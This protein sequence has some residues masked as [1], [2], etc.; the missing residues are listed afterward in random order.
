MRASGIFMPIFSL[1]SKYGI[2]TL[3]KE[4][5]TFADFLCKSGQ[6][7]WQ[8]L[9]LNPTDEGGSPYRSFSAM[10]GNPYLIDLTIL[11]DN[12]L[13]TF[14]ECEAKDFGDDPTAVD[15]GKLD[16]NRYRLLRSAFER[17]DTETPEFLNFCHSERAWLDDYAL[18]MVLKDSYSGKPWREWHNDIKFRKPAA[19]RRIKNDN[20]RK[21][22]FYKFLQFEFFSQWF[23]LK[24]YANGRGIRIVGDIPIYVSDDSVDVWCNTKLFDLD[25]NL[26]PRVIAGCP[27]DAYSADGQLWGMP[28]Y[29]WE[30]MKTEKKPYSWW[31]ARISHALKIYDTVRI[32]H[33][34]GFESYYCIKYDS[35]NAKKGKW[36]K[37]PGPEL[38]EYFRKDHGKNKKLPIIAE[39]LGYL[40]PEVRKL[41]EDTGLPGMKVL[42]FAFDPSGKSDYLPHNHIRNC[43]VYTGTHDNDTVMGWV[44]SADPR[45]VAYARRYMHVDDNEG[46]NWAM[47]RTAMMSV[48]DTCIIMMADFMGLDSSARINTP[49]TVGC[50]WKWRIDGSCIN[51]WLAGIIRE[52]TAMYGRLGDNDR[53]SKKKNK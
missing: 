39:D 21:I 9:P 51:D 26:C 43:V 16:N 30:Y 18:F 48:A 29:N 36:R 11:C 13:L 19:L 4:A 27:P 2:G 24:T 17:F 33:F 37:G 14:A 38:F 28:V 12:G 52:N 23:A 32:D 25:E 40:T 31:R 45:E 50:N 53:I 44:S 34:R 6:S 20:V 10:A 3:G 42:Q 1:P 8:I 41:L 49:S 46:F 15:Y 22:E 5:Y 7:Y 35:K 47:I